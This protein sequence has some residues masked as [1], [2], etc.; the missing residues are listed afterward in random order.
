MKKIILDL[1][2]GSRK[3]AGAIGIDRVKVPGVDII[4]DLNEKLPI[5]NDSVDM[6]YSYHF[7]EHVGDFLFTVEEIY[8]VAKNNAIIQIKVPYFM[9]FDAF[10][11]P[12]HRKFFTERAFDY[13]AD[14][15]YFNYYSKARFK[16]LKKNLVINPN[17]RNKILSFFIPR[18][19]LKA[20]FDVYNEIEF[21]LQVIK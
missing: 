20:I 7:L 10:T 2:C 13:F 3:Y 17:I 19:Y 16:I 4:A 1:G 6:I 12:T 14:K 9:C 21:N 11:D 18:R 15:I 8:R 5:K